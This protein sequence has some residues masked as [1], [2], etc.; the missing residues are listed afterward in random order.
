MAVEKTTELT[1]HSYESHRLWEWLVSDLTNHNLGKQA[2]SPQ[3]NEYFRN[4]TR[5]SLKKEYLKA[6][7]YKPSDKPINDFQSLVDKIPNLTEEQ[8]LNLKL[9]NIR[10]IQDTLCKD[11]NFSTALNLM[12][13]KSMNKLIT[14]TVDLMTEYGIAFRKE[15]V[16]LFKQQDMKNYIYIC[17]KYQKCCCCGAEGA[18]IHHV[19]H[20]T[21]IGGRKYD[22]GTKLRIMP[23]CRTCHTKAHSIGEKR[24]Y[25][26]NEIEGILFSEE[27][28]IKF[29]P[30]YKNQFKALRGK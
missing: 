14:Y 16:D 10:C 2:G 26:E 4:Q 13:Q 9:A 24:F 27:E 18:E 5:L 19:D 12:N 25:I 21:K 8:R 20:V 28:I 22:D 11:N 30:H 23:L 7:G 29:M 15:I 1:G 3:E 6:I 17:L